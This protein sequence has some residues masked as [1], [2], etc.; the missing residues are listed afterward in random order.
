V[1]LFCPSPQLLFLCSRLDSSYYVETT[2]LLAVEPSETLFWVKGE[3][4]LQRSK[5]PQGDDVGLLSRFIVLF[6]QNFLP[7]LV[8]VSRLCLVEGVDS[9]YVRWTAEAKN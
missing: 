1:R 4:F 6:F 9:R 7:C 8:T 5:L 3:V 2:G